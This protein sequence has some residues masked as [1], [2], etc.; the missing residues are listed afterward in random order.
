MTSLR[1]HL[2]APLALLA[3]AACAHAP[4]AA[5]PPVAWPEA[6]AAPRLRLVALWSP[7][8][9]RAEARGTLR[10]LA[11]LLAGEEADAAG[12]QLLARPFGV[13][14]DDEGRLLVADPD[15]R[16]VLRLAPDGQVRSIACAE[17]P[18]VAPMALAAGPGG[19]VY[20][21]DAAGEVVEVR[22]GQPCR[23]LG[24]GAFAHPTGLLLAG[25][26]LL[27]ADPGRDE[28]L[29]APL[30]G[31]PV[32]RFAPAEGGE[33]LRNPIALALAADGAVL[34]VDALHFRVVRLAPD[35]AWLG[36][37][38]APE[39]GGGL[40]RPKGVA[41][42]AAGRVYVSDAERDQVL[43]FDAGGAALE[44]FGGSGDAPGALAAPAGLAVAGDRLYVADS[45]NSRIQVFAILGERP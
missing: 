26:R 12:P 16:T 8:T 28:V 27:V 9:I 5:P 23:A 33:P 21:A 34:V 38:T 37:F 2:L 11:G 41:V 13:A 22:P 24:R 29:A 14:T 25:G 40:R 7:A 39:E 44:A 36:A 18:W 4:A 31:G 43:R 20:V 10:R 30:D 19:A 6:P 1:R 15:A 42:D 32:S 3:A 35:G 45:L 17:R